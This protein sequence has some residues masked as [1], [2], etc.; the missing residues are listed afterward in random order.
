MSLSTAMKS[1]PIMINNTNLSNTSV[2]PGEQYSVIHQL[3]DPSTS[4]PN[5]FMFNLKKR[6]SV[7]NDFINDAIRKSE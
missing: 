2:L 4:P 1:I 7:Y 6:I 5:T 3:F